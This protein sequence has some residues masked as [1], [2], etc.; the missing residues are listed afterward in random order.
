MSKIRATY[1]LLR[2]DPTYAG[3]VKF[4]RKG[5]FFVAVEEEAFAVSERYGV[6]LTKLAA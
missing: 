1:D 3:T 6:E 2:A 5:T 4:F